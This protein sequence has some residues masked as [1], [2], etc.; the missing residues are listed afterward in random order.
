M[1]AWHQSVLLFENRRFVLLL[2][3]LIGIF[4]FQFFLLLPLLITFP[5]ISQSELQV[6]KTPRVNS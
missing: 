6:S 5:E 1:H 3:G 4:A 2:I